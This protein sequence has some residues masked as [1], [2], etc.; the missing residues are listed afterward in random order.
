MTF[1]CEWS[2]TLPP[3]TPAM[4]LR[5]VVP[6]WVVPAAAEVRVRARRRTPGAVADARAQMAHLLDA[7]RP[8]DVDRAA[9]A[10]LERQVLR[11]ELRYQP[12]RIA[13]QDVEGIAHLASARRRGRGVVLKLPAPR[14]LRGC[15]RIRGARRCSRCGSWSTR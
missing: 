6:A 12:R 14:A 7:V 13:H 1:T 4:R 11:S 8:D 10:Y 5:R 2:G 3:P 15:V 9:A